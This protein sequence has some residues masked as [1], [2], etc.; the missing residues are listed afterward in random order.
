MICI[1]VYGVP[2]RADAIN[3]FIFSPLVVSMVRY[4]KV[5][6]ADS[7]K[8][9]SWA[10]KMI[11]NSTNQKTDVILET[12]LYPSLYDFKFLKYP[13]LTTNDLTKTQLLNTK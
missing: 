3:W 9:N 5:Y 11:F 4:I 6:D 8:E 13:T 12:H 2:I 10:N 1:D 7:S